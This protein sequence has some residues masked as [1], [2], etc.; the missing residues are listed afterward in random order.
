MQNA[1][2]RRVFGGH[3]SGTGGLESAGASLKRMRPELVVSKQKLRQAEGC[4]MVRWKREEGKQN[5]GFSSRPFVLCGLPVRKP[6]AGEMLYERGNGDVVLKI[7]K[8]PNYRLPFGQDRIV[9]F[10][11]PRLRC[12]SR[13]KRVASARLRRCWKRSE[14][15]RRQGV[16]AI[17]RRLR[18]NLRSNNLF[19]DGHAPR[20]SQ[21]GRKVAIQFLP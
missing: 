1:N 18:A 6:P 16:P 21:G 4:C 20:Y 13:A 9:R 7:T 19:R 12:A 17:G 5:L 11:W 8:H 14:C 10:T 15:T 3:N 2:A